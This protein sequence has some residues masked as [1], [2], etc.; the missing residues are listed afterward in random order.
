MSEQHTPEP[1]KVIIRGDYGDG[2]EADITATFDGMR[3]T[4]KAEDARRIVAC[5]NACAGIETTALELMTGELSIHNQI[6][7]THPEKLTPKATE[8]RKQRDDLVAACNDLRCDLT[9][10]RSGWEFAF[11][12]IHRMTE[13]RDELL[14]AIKTT[15]E[16]NLHL[17]DGDVCTLIA[18]KRAYEKA[19]GKPLLEDEQKGGAA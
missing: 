8:Y 9:D 13:R 3:G 7:H 19:T 12:E 18:I 1:W 16:E 6:T 5:V 2:L 14:M 4:L 10:A 11:Q 15:L 17:A